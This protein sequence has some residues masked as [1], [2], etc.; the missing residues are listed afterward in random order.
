MRRA[1]PVGQHGPGERDVLTTDDADQ[2][3][4]VGR[5]PVQEEDVGKLRAAKRKP[6]GLILDQPSG[7][8]GDPVGAHAAHAGLVSQHGERRRADVLGDRAAH[9]GYAS[10]LVP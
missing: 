5:R 8:Q 10:E 1:A 3:G 2:A 7:D 6:A 4:T 9:V